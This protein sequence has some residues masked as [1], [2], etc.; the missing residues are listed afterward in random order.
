MHISSDT[1]TANCAEESIPLIVFR[2]CIVFFCVFL[3]GL[4]DVRGSEVICRFA[5]TRMRLELNDKTNSI[6]LSSF[7]ETPLSLACYRLN[8][9][10]LPTPRAYI[11]HI[12]IFTSPAKS[13]T[14]NAHTIFAFFLFIFFHILSLHIF[15]ADKHRRRFRH[16][17]KQ[18]SLFLPGSVYSTC[19]CVCVFARAPR[20][21]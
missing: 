8:R 21:R 2:K 12:C 20:K 10:P 7:V 15:Q 14:T 19:V 1:K 4:L 13:S 3:F 9:A 6:F 17:Q 18:S 16:A 11:V 5:S